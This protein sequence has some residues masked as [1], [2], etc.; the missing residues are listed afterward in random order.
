METIFS[1]NELEISQRLIF[2]NSPIIKLKGNVLTPAHKQKLAGQHP[3]LLCRT[4]NTVPGAIQERDSSSSTSV[5]G[6][7]LSSVTL[8]I[9]RKITSVIK[10][11]KKCSYYNRRFGKQIYILNL[12]SFV[13]ML[14]RK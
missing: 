11:K 3:E 8:S 10:E 9:L 13:Q 12:L 14:Q 1:T 2:D 4:S 7:P 6:R 5:S